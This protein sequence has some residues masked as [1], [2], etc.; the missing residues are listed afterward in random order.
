MADKLIW[1][2][3]RANENGVGYAATPVLKF[4]NN[5]VAPFPENSTFIRVKNLTGPNGKLYDYYTVK[6]TPMYG[7]LISNKSSTMDGYLNFLMH[8]LEKPPAFVL[9]TEKGRCVENGGARY[10]INHG[11]SIPF[12]NVN[13]FARGY[14]NIEKTLLNTNNTPATK[15]RF[16]YF[17]G[18]TEIFSN[19]NTNV[20]F[21]GQAD[22]NLCYRAITTK[23][24]VFI[25]STVYQCLNVRLPKPVENIAL[26]NDPIRMPENKN[27]IIIDKSYTFE[28]TPANAQNSITINADNTTNGAV[29]STFSPAATNVT[30]ATTFGVKA[31]NLPSQGFTFTATNPSIPAGCLN[32]PYSVHYDVVSDQVVSSQGYM[33]DLYSTGMPY[34]GKSYIRVPAAN[35]PNASAGT[36]RFDFNTSNFTMEA[37]VQGKTNT[38]NLPLYTIFS[39][40][41]MSSGQAGFRFGVNPTTNKLYFYSGGA[42]SFE[43]DAL[44]TGTFTDNTC[45]HVAVVRENTVIKFYINGVLSGTRTINGTMNINNGNFYLIGTDTE[46][47]SHQGVTLPINNFVGVIR[48]ARLWKEA[49]DVLFLI[50]NKGRMIPSPRPSTLRSYLRLN[51]GVG[52]I[53]KDLADAFAPLQLHGI[54][55]YQDYLPGQSP[56][57]GTTANWSTATC[58][59][60]IFR[61][62]ADNQSNIDA[63]ESKSEINIYPNPTSG[64]IDIN[65]CAEY[66]I[67]NTQFE[68]FDMQGKKMMTQNISGLITSLDLSHLQN[69]MYLIKIQNQSKAK[70]FKLV[71]SK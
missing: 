19:A 7:C 18:T 51:D 6:I 21:N 38:Y 44:A 4:I 31:G 15:A 67:E 36:A 45:R 34:R 27:P 49:K 8:D 54:G 24:L 25:P 14:L 58:N 71:L 11:T 10:D 53:A 64:N 37:W 61:K 62:D 70:N 22:F 16:E 28:V 69:G 5:N 42:N 9:N 57:S 20:D 40:W 13:S 29:A 56:K 35:D 63:I 17:G 46:E 60:M 59:E 32:T 43:S 65:V 48:E 41:T 12:Y 23:P 1:E 2:V 3:L 33:F 47:R 30:N 55:L 39:N 50:A 66:L 52:V 26:V 68:L